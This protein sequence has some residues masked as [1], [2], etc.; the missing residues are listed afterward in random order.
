MML[1]INTKGTLMRFVSLL[2]AIL[3]LAACA[4]SPYQTGTEARQNRDNMLKLNIGQTKDQVL[5][6]MGKPYK[7]EM[8]ASEEKP[9]EFWLYLTEGKGIY[10]RTLRDSN[11]TP[12]AF[13]NGVLKGWGRNYYDKTLR[14]KKD[15]TI[16]LK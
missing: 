16:E 12:L 13:E 1:T 3:F 15:I 9:I 7:T 14:V 2:F 8:Y 5:A 4:G 6:L 10:D 11:F